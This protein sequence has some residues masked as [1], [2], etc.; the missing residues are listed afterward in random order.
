LTDLPSQ[1][2]RIIDANLDRATEGLRVLEDVARFV[3]DSSPL[4]AKLKELRHG[5]HDAFAELNMCLISA[6]DSAGDVGRESE[7]VK[8][9]AAGLIETVIANARR[10]EQS[11]RVLEELSRLP[12]A[13]TGSAAF[14]EAR[15]AVYDI[16]KE[17]VSRLS[18][19]DKIARLTGFYTVVENKEEFAAAV[20][21][22]ASAVQFNPGVA[23][24]RESLELAA[25][26]RD[27]CRENGVLFIVGEYIDI[28]MA[29][30]ADGV[31]IDCDSLPVAVVRGLLD[32]DQI[33]GFA[34]RSFDE[35]FGAV[36]AGA[37]YLI[38]T[39][40]ELGKLIASQGIIVVNQT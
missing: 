34:P 39:D 16:E 26:F 9:P 6:R 24:R 17:L 33:I 29:V 25:D 23:R 19:R 15:F 28:A 38:C 14:E 1:A 13:V 27:T 32:I 35:G 37:D 21:R 11:L 2:L 22:K 5:L 12:D 31:V 8:E 40:R 4:A 36:E 20:E 30:K 3:L 18:R 7:V 10:V